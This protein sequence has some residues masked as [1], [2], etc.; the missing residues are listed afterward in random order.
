M[1]P[2]PKISRQMIV[3][4]AFHVIQEKGHEQMNVRAIAERLN[5]ST[6]PVMYHFKSIEEI[7]KEVYRMADAYH[8]NYIMPKGNGSINPILE[9]GLNYIQ[10]GYE[11]KNLFR[12]LFQTNGFSDVSIMNLISAPEAS[13]ILQ[14]VSEGMKCSMEEAKSV[15]FNLFVSAHGIASLLANNA[16]EYEEENFKTVLKNAYCGISNLHK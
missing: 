5:C 9:L 4:A 10:F 12:F 14:L 3:D 15:F 16:L 2:K 13:E 6:Q 7:R 1:P 8:S 11:Q